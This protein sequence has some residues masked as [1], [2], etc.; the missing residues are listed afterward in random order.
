MHFLTAIIAL[1]DDRYEMLVHSKKKNYKE[2]NMSAIESDKMI[3][4]SIQIK[5][6]EEIPLNKFT[7]L[8]DRIKLT[9][10]AVAVWAEIL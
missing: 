1:I 10:P 9:G 7:H 5:L 8:I 2:F 6:S 3:E 4:L